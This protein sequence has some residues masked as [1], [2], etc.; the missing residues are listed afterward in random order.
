LCRLFDDERDSLRTA[1]EMV[2]TANVKFT[3]L[4]TI[5]LAALVSC[6]SARPVGVDVARSPADDD[7]PRIWQRTQIDPGF[8][9]D[10]VTALKTSAE[11]SY[12]RFREIR[13]VFKPREYERLIDRL[14]HRFVRTEGVQRLAFRYGRVLLAAWVVDNIVTGIIIPGVLIGIGHPTLAAASF[15]LPTHPFTYL[16][17]FY[18]ADVINRRRLES[19]LGIQGLTALDALKKELLGFDSSKRI[20]RVLYQETV[21]EIEQS[22]ELQVLKR[23][24]AR[25]AS[26]GRS[27]L[28]GLTELVSLVEQSGTEGASF[29]DFLHRARSEEVYYAAE[30][31]HFAFSHEGTRRE[32]VK[33]MRP[34]AADGSAAASLS[35][36]QSL[37]TDAERQYLSWTSRKQHIKA[38]ASDM[39]DKRALEIIKDR[40]AELIAFGHDLLRREYLYLDQIRSGA[41][42]QPFEIDSAIAILQAQRDLGQQVDRMLGALSDYNQDS[43]LETANASEMTYLARVQ[44]TQLGEAPRFTCTGGADSLLSAK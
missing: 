17:T 1:I 32:L 43:F 41:Q 36:I 13:E 16:A 26:S 35:R 5:C 19:E 20:T 29:V 30:L 8:D 21:N 22:L 9:A 6:T 25:S 11:A 27:G 3:V 24:K 37:R 44:R 4:M 31:L 28:V 23:V 39:V 2:D 42:A 18:M 40:Q 14:A 12:G 38:S 7:G 10:F 34:A 15:F 33:K